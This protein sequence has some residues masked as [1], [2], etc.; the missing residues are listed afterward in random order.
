MADFCKQCSEVLFG[1]DSHDFAGITSPDDTAKGLY[2][3]ALCEGCGATQVDH[4]GKCIHH[5]AERHSPL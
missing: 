1:E 4:E 5:E 3:T 2:L